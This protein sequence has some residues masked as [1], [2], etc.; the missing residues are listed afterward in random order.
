MDVS[1]L[2]VGSQLCSPCPL[3][4]ADPTAW[5]D[6]C[7]VRAHAMP[8]DRRQ[9]CLAAMDFIVTSSARYNVEDSTLTMEL[10]QLGLPRS[11]SNSVAR[12]Y[13]DGRERLREALARAVVRVSRAGAAY[14]QLCVY[15]C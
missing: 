4:E 9:A 14:V 13:R 11:N 5:S 1:S 15:M 3:I 8:H 6:R 10:Q 2:K 7:L 12:A